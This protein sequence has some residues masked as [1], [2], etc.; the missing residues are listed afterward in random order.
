MF[1]T[2]EHLGPVS[3]PCSCAPCQPRDHMLEC[4]EPQNTLHQQQPAAPASLPDPDV[5]LYFSQRSSLDPSTSDTIEGGWSCAVPVA[6]TAALQPVLLPADNSR[7]YSDSNHSY[8]SD[9]SD[10]KLRQP[11]NCFPD[12]NVKW[13]VAAWEKWNYLQ[14]QLN[15]QISTWH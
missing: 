12:K 4:W 9:F 2:R 6:S 5:A 14:Q 7:D 8:F 10:R 13:S 15:L 11:G 3:V 1:W